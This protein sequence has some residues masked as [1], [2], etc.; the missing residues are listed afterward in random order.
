MI[1]GITGKMQNGKDT[2][3]KIIQEIY[4]YYKIIHYA[5]P[6]KD[7]CK[8]FLGLSEEDVNTSEGKLKYNEFWGMT[9]REILQKIGTEALRKG[10]REDFWVKLMSLK[11]KAY[12][13]FIIPD[14]RFN[15]EAELVLKNHGMMI[16]INRESVNQ[17]R[18]ELNHISELGIDNKL[19]TYDIE[20]NG[21]IEDLKGKVMECFQ[22]F[23]R[24]KIKKWFEEFRNIKGYNS[25]Y[26]EI[27]NLVLDMKHI[28]SWVYFSPE[29]DCLQV[30]YQE[31]SFE[32]LKTCVYEFYFECD[33]WKIYIDK[34]IKGTE[35]VSQEEIEL[36][37]LKDFRIF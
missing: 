7:F 4:P 8:Q 12:D 18:K 1:I 5:D 23:H 28:D 33:K 30:E 17:S 15:D 26:D 29:H 22:D 3:A 21:T 25:K 14:V 11:I 32:C 36:E 16:R 19:V 31:G 27:E 10:F 20:N 37:T 13:N 2:L 9:N 24:K 6:L 34:Y 35:D